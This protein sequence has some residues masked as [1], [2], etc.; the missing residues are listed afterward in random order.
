MHWIAAFATPFLVGLYGLTMEAVGVVL[1]FAHVV[2]ASLVVAALSR[3]RR[4]PTARKNY[5]IAARVLWP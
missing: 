5:V 1:S 2:Q 3:R 4:L